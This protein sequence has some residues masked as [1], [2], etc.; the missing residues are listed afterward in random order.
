MSSGFNLSKAE[1][2]WLLKTARCAIA[3]RLS[4]SPAVPNDE[5]LS[6]I[7][8]EP[9]GVF[10]TLRKKGDLRGC[11]GFTD[12]NEPLYKNVK[13]AAISA[14]FNDTRFAPVKED[15]LGEIDIEISVL[16]APAHV[17]FWEEIEIG[18]HGIILSKNGRR[19]VFLPQVAVEFGWEL[20]ETLTHL[21]LKAG[22]LESDWRE[23]ASF[24]VFE[25]I[26][27]TKKDTL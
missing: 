12:S 4:G 3:A 15:E 16:G 22:L 20:E 6:E 10:V 8:K 17:E 21:A 27:F 11:V 2:L 26:K 1:K 19:S 23:G 14:A 9:C 13:E 18:R 7:L 25:S 24:E 5:N